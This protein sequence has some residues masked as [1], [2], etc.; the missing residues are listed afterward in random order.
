ME[1]GTIPIKFFLN[2]SK[3]EQKKRFLERIDMPEKNWKFSVSDAKERKFW[4]RYMSAYEDVFSNT[5]TD[6]APWYIIPADNKWF[7]RLAVAE[8]INYRLEKLN[9]KYPTVTEAHRIELMQARRMLV[10]E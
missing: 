5:S 2:V 7:M 10:G 6:Y 3:S 1:N 9:L 8:V 4:K